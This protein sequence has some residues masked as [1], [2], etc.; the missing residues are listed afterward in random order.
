MP[1]VFTVGYSTQTAAEFDALLMKYDVELVVD[2]RSKPSSRF[3]RFKR[4]PLKIR[5]LDAGIDYLYL[6]EELGG[7][8]DKD[9][10]YTNGRVTYERVTPLRGFRRGIKQVAKDCEL[11][12]L[13]LMCAE[14][15]PS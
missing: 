12:R 1:E 8:P 2:V 11:Y 10:L 5:L 15:D 4:E 9:E 3:H 13:A 7:Y 14:E 6:G